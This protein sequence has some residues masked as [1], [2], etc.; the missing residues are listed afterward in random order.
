MSS[1]EAPSSVPAPEALR[2]ELSAPESLA[3]DDAA[4][5]DVLLRVEARLI[6]LPV[7]NATAP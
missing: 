6:A 7:Y 1:S 4:F 2:A 5:S 3:R